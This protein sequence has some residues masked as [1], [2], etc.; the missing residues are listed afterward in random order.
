MLAYFDC[1]SGISGDMTLGA[2]VDAGVDVDLLRGELARL[3]V[4]GYTLTA[5]RFSSKGLQGTLVRVGLDPGEPQPHR[6]LSDVLSIIEG[7]SL[8]PEVKR[9]ASAVFRRLAEAEA[10]VHGTTV[11]QVHFHEVGAVDAIVDVVGSI[12][13]LRALGV[14]RVFASSL[15][16]G[17]GTVQTAHGLL[18]VP[19]PATLEL[20]TQA[21]A[22]MRPSE[23]R[24]ELVTPTGAALLAELA[25]FQ[26][27]GA[28]ALASRDRL[29]SEAASLGEL[30]APDPRRPDRRRYPEMP[31][32]TRSSS[33]KRTSTT[34]LPSYSARP[35]EGSSRLARSTSTSRR[36][37]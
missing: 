12:V 31:R 20:L 6:H 33:S 27:A 11:E 37:R 18:P 17:S 29:R 22:P 2:L 3:P 30:P 24:T 9:R 34:R 32:K 14:E 26:R 23:A 8:E 1:F 19:A 5:E 16:M 4:K 36:S 28:S 10:K 25:E 35:W 13:G 7:S 21:R 15:P